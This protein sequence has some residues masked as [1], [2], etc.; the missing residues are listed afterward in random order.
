MFGSIKN[1][2]VP[3]ENQN[4]HVPFENVLQHIQATDW[5][6]KFTI[7]LTLS[8]DCANASLIFSEATSMSVLDQQVLFKVTLR[9]DDENV[10]L[11]VE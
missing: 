3:F 7:Q 10:S 11:G 5:Y 1:E 2:H 4:E 6:S 9:A 8:T